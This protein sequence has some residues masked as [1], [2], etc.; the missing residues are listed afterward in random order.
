MTT[1]DRIFSLQGRGL[2][3]DT[4]TDVEPLLAGVDP[5]RIEEVH[6][7]GNTVGIGASEAIAD[8]LRQATSLKVADFADIFTGRLISEIPQALSN[9]CDALINTDTLVEI[10]LSDNAFGGRS[11]DPIVPFLTQNRS[12]QIL[13]LNNNGLGPAGGAVIAEALLKSAQL[14]KAEGKKSNLRTVI[15]GRNRL[16]DGSASAW[17]AAF[18]EHGG[19]VE[20]RMPQNGIRM[21]GIASL[22][23]GI[24]ANPN[25]QHLDLQDN[26][27]A[28]KGSKAMAAAL[29]SWPELA[30]LN[31][32]DCVLA[33]EGEVSPVIAPLLSGVLP[34]LHH[35][36][37]QN[38]NLDAQSFA[39]LAEGI[40]EFLP[41]LKRLEVQWNDFESED[42]S[43]QAL[44]GILQRRGGKLII[45][46]EDEEEEEEEEE[47]EAAEEE[48]EQQEEAAPAPAAA[49]PAAPAST[50]AT[51]TTAAPIEAAPPAETAKETVK[52]E[53]AKDPADALAD[54]LDKVT[55]G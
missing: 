31:L 50:T 6:F 28:E 3:L 20:I 40:P 32:S 12:F 52:T 51:T 41:L 22:V 29:K 7:G 35:L 49:T 4:R 13:K 11:V 37:L 48:E 47:E 42:E 43:I 24:S 9:I 14:S 16:E 23:E 1:N 38:N 17:A 26:T 55:I 2:H 33:D 53:S 8:F 30:T 34:K 36:Q 19:L 27:F 46:D 25:L 45:D 18:K 15:C 54:L 44:L 39:L 5:T 21:D 10:N